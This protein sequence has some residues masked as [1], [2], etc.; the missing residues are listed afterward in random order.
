MEKSLLQVN[1]RTILQ[2]HF[3]QQTVSLPEGTIPQITVLQ[4]VCL[5][6]PVM[7]GLL[8]IVLP[9][10]TQLP[11]DSSCNIHLGMIDTTIYQLLFT[12]GRY[13]HGLNMFKPKLPF[14]IYHLPLSGGLFYYYCF[15]NINPTFTNINPTLTQH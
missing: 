14:T 9:T 3:L 10:F 1:Q 12:V 4:V 13:Y 5:P 8:I 11:M 15:T 7:G 2:D 6:F